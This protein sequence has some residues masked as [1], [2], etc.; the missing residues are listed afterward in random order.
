[1]ILKFPCTVP[2]ITASCVISIFVNMQS[3]HHW[4]IPVALVVMAANNSYHDQMQKMKV[5][6]ESNSTQASEINWDQAFQT[7]SLWIRWIKKM[8]V[9]KV[10]V[11]QRAFNAPLKG[12]EGQQKAGS[13]QWKQQH[14]NDLN[15]GQSTIKRDR[16][17]VISSC[18]KITARVGN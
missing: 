18:E 12:F 5:I 10:A 16:S 9:V 14:K 1:M 15:K 6:C 8:S 4:T 11:N 3:Q 13:F 2:K 7:N 17:W